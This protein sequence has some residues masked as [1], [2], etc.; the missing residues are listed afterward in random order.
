MHRSPL[1]GFIID[2]ETDDLRAAGE[3][4]S[5]AL[6]LPVRPSAEAEDRGYIILD[7]K[8]NQPHLEVQKV[9]HS[10]RVHLDIESDN[11]E[12]EVSR[13]ERLGAKRV[14]SVRSWVVMDAPTGQRF[15]VVKAARGN[16][17]ADANRWD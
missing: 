16:F 1:G 17:A 11:V 14:K 4:W 6:G 5:Q 3:F 10:S 13:L 7:T 15:C 2:C 9:D 12:A 8:Q